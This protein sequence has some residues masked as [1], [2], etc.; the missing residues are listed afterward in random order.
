MKKLTPRTR[1]VALGG[2]LKDVDYGMLKSLIRDEVALQVDRKIREVI[3]PLYQVILADDKYTL[4][5]ETLA[6]WLQQL[7]DDD[8]LIDEEDVPFFLR[9]DSNLWG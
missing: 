5:Q 8:T 1:K 2:K 7:L 3:K 6:P 9:D 4:D